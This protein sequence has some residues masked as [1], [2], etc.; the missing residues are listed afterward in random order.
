M[1]NIK[2]ILLMVAAMA[3]FTLADL[4]IKRVG[5]DLPTGEI[6]FIM[7][8]GG[9]LVFGIWLLKSGQALF[10]ADF[11]SPVI[12][13]RNLGEIVGTFGIM[14]AVILIPI[15]SVSAIMQ[16]A[17]LMVTMGAALFLGATVGWRRWSAIAVGFLGVLIII[18]PGMA[19]FQPES[20]FAVLGVVGQ[21]ARDLSTRAAPKSVSSLRIGFY[22]VVSLMIL[23]AVLMLV[24]TPPVMPERS[25]LPLLILMTGLGTFG[26]HM[27][28]LSMR[29]GDVAVVVPFRYSRILFGI[30]G[31]ML[32]FA[33]RPDFW[34]YFGA[35]IIILTG[36]YSFMRERKRRSAA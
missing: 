18:R 5:Q 33:E 31:G 32:V 2:G 22:G 7:G 19:G 15:S 35:A 28:N 16:A 24:S 25:I 30:I 26:Y 12:L 20:L 34:T 4:C 13:L 3:T 6:L 9:A 23:G 14:T 17:P 8:L 1:D 27:L 10:A 11:L 36:L 29:L 21:A